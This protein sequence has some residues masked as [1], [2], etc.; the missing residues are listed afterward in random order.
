M[1]G[2]LYEEPGPIGRRRNAVIAVVSTIVVLG[3]VGFCGIQLASQ[4][5]FAAERWAVLGRVDLLT[6]ILEGLVATLHAGL[7]CAVLS[8]LAGGILVFGRMS[9]RRWLR[10]AVAG[11][12]EVFRGVPP[13]LFIFF[14]FLGL[15]IAGVSV[16]TFWTLVIG[17]TCYNAPAVAEIYRAGIQALPQGQ[18]L[19]GYS[20]GLRRGQCFRLIVL[21]QAILPTMPALISQVVMI[22]KETA[23]GFIIGYEEMLRRAQSSV[24]YLG[25]Q[26][27][28]PVYV[29]VA[30]IYITVCLAVSGLAILAARKWRNDTGPWWST[31]AVAPQEIV[32]DAKN[33][34]VAAVG[35]RE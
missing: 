28:L 8:L 3:V 34:L 17:L 22:L 13:L 14:I 20:V 19:A 21:P 11:L 30:S 5:A 16:S 15:P 9:E 1:S 27:A 10:G 35:R 2:K 33:D 31:R 6:L 4:G 23:L 32:G 7:L 12:I 18:T 29:L 26:Y 25:G 24:E